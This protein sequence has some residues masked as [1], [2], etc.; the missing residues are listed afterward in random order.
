MRM[1]RTSDRI[2]EAYAVLEEFFKEL[3]SFKDTLI[4]E[5]DVRLKIIDPILIDVL[6]WA[7]EDI[8]T[9]DRSGKN[10]VDYKISIQGVAKLVLEAKRAQRTFDLES[11][12]CG[13]TYR[14]SG[15]A[16]KN[17]DLLEGIY[18]AIEYS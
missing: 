16:F 12:E 1:N 10:Y 7:K 18:Q 5:S 2:D 13:H 4:T 17:K 6:G 3:P 14:L 8:F 9:E 11:R 15:P